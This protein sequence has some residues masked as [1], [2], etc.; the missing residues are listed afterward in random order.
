[1]LPQKNTDRVEG[2]DKT[3]RGGGGEWESIK[4]PQQNSTYVP[5]SIQ[6]ATLLT[7]PRPHSY[8][9]AIDN[10]NRVSYY[11]VPPLNKDA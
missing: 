4:I 10:Q 5:K 8:R 3:I 2:P 11:D 1:M 6:H 9:K 7:Q